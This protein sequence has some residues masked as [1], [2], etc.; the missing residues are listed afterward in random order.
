LATPQN[1]VILKYA[2]PWLCVLLF[3]WG[4]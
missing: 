1:I 3:K 2:K 4:G